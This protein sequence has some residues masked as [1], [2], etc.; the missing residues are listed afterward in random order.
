M[1]SILIV[2]SAGLDVIVTTRVVEQPPAKLSRRT[3]RTKANRVHRISDDLLAHET[4]GAT[5]PCAVLRGMQVSGP[6]ATEA[7][8]DRE[9]G[10]AQPKLPQ[11]ASAPLGM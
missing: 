10:S 5:Y 2:A 7:A 9:V 11:F 6:C 8:H 1:P 3:N 4:S